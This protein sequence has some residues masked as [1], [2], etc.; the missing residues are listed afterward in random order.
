MLG[1]SMDPG[2]SGGGEDLVGGFG[3]SDGGGDGGGGDFGGG[4]GDGGGGF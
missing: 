4:F 3:G 2:Y 1:G